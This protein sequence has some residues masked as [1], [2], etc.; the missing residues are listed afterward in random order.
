[1]PLLESTGGGAS[2]PNRPFIELKRLCRAGVMCDLAIARRPELTIRSSQK[3][4]IKI[5]NKSESIKDDHKVRNKGNASAV[6]IG[7]RGKRR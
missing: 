4:L 3:T 7:S 6:G 2:M 1:M 5:Y